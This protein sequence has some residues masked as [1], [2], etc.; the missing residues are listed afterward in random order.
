MSKLREMYFYFIRYPTIFLFFLILTINYFCAHRNVGQDREN[1]P[2]ALYYF[3]YIR[4]FGHVQIYFALFKLKASKRTA[5]C[6]RTAFVFIPT[7]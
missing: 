3:Y 5:T 7:S 6:L 4:I 2:S 1:E